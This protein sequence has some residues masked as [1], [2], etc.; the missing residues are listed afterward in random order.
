M[1]Y[2]LLHSTAVQSSGDVMQIL[3]D[4]EEPD[5]ATQKLYCTGEVD[6]VH[7]YGRQCTLLFIVHC[8][9]NGSTTVHSEE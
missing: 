8:T 3:R 2:I 5:A 4:C 1:L 7:L 6:T 9:V